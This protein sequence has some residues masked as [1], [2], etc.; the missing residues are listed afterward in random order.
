MT[1][2]AYIAALETIADAAAR[3]SGSVNL[4]L[5]YNIAE[6]IQCVR[7]GYAVDVHQLGLYFDE[8]KSI[9]RI[10]KYDPR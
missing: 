7:D 9:A 3:L 8:L 5:H 1:P 6:S 2:R 4:N 10:Y